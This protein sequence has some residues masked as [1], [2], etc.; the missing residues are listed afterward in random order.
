MM[1]YGPASPGQ[2]AAV[3]HRPHRRHV[4]L[5]AGGIFILAIFVLNVIAQL[6]RPSQG[7]TSNCVTPPPPTSP[8]LTLSK[9]FHSSS[10]GFSLAYD[11]NYAGNPTSSGSSKVAWEF[12]LKSGG[13]LDAQVTGARTG[14]QT[15]EEAV[16]SEQTGHFSQFQLVYSIPIAEVGYTVGAGEILEGQWNP[17]LGSSSTERLAILAAQRRGVT[18]TITCEAPKVSDNGEHA[19]PAEIGIGAD[20]FCDQVMNTVTWKGERPL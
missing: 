7:C 3:T 9:A 18:V 17:L 19:N 8:P 13:F 5:S 14:G 15:P 6:S 1:A 2:I 12:P 4:W 20:Q 10:L 16:S 11:P